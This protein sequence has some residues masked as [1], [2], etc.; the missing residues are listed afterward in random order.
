MVVEKLTKK[1]LLYLGI[2][3]LAGL[4][5]L[6]LVWHFSKI[7]EVEE[8][9]LPQKPSEEE[10]QRQIIQE[11]LKELESLR[12]ETAT[13]TEEEIQTQLKELEKLQQKQKPLSPEEI[14]K[15]LEELEKLR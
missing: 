13:L 9:P 2:I 6:G 1:S 8:I 5:C 3:I 12:T 4:I 14:Q 7:P 11:Q 15:Q 10:R